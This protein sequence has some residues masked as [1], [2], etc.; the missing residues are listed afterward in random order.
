MHIPLDRELVCPH[1]PSPRV[2]LSLLDSCR[3]VMTRPKRRADHEHAACVVPC[4]CRNAIRACHLAPPL[5]LPPSTPAQ[6]HCTK[7]NGAEAVRRPTKTTSAPKSVFLFGPSGAVDAST[8]SL[9]G[10]LTCKVSMVVRNRRR[11]TSAPASIMVQVCGA[12]GGPLATT[13][14]CMTTGCACQSLGRPCAGIHL[15]ARQPATSSVCA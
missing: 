9:K 13:T 1:A 3:I 8:R 12:P 6:L 5:Q 15:G 11:L 4:R 14:C 10:V 7:I 2:S